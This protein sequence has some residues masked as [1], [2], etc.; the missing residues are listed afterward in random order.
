[1]SWLTT[2]WNGLPRELRLAVAVG[3]VAAMLSAGLVVGYLAWNNSDL[4]AKLGV[5]ATKADIEQQTE[6]IAEQGAVAMDNVINGALQQYDTDLRSYLEGERNAAIDTIL[7]PMLYALAELDKRQR[8]MQ[9]AT[10]ANARRL[11]E[12]PKAY[13]SQMERLLTA[14]E[15]DESTRLLRDILGR[16]EAIEQERNAPE[17]KRTTKKQF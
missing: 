2:L 15:G 3:V 14:A 13:G 9:A 4:P 8:Q 16:L 6:T 1:M 10:D 12:I 11:E 5:V 7:T 17:P